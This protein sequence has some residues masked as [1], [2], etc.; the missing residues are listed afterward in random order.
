MRLSA[1]QSGIILSVMEKYGV[2][3]PS[4]PALFNQCAE[5]LVE[6]GSGGEL[7]Y[8]EVH[9]ICPMLVGI[10]G[11]VDLLR[12]GLRVAGASSIISIKTKT[13]CMNSP[14]R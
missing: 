2:A 5:F 8:G 12:F 7:L 13:G 10:G 3:L 9:A 4:S 1:K 11:I 6:V 14:T